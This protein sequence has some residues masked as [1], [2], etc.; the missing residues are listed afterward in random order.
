MYVWSQ[1]SLD[2]FYFF[3]TAAVQERGRHWAFDTHLPS[4]L[5]RHPDK[6]ATR[7]PEA[8]NQLASVMQV[9]RHHKLDA[10]KPSNR[11]RTKEEEKLVNIH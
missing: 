6:R 8:A 4:V 1:I 3:C 7:N 11:R 9:K 5:T 2:F 10:T